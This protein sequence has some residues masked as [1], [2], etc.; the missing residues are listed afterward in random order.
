MHAA[1]V[2]GWL[3]PP[4]ASVSRK[5]PRT[6]AGL[7][8][9]AR[10]GS[11]IAAWG[12]GGGGGWYTAARKEG[13]ARSGRDRRLHV[14]GVLDAGGAVAL[15][16]VGAGDAHALRLALATLERHPQA[17]ALRVARQALHLV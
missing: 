9:R 10:L 15:V 11:A 8:I 14:L 16:G 13:A 12:V 3:A 17:L 4:P 5:K 6:F 1:P 2:P 7:T